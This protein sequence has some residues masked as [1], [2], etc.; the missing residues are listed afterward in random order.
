MR[1]IQ[2]LAIGLLCAGAS[3]VA[4]AADPAAKPVLVDRIAAVV[5]DDVVLYREYQ[6]RVERMKAALGKRK[7]PQK[8]L[9]KTALDDLIND[10][11]IMHVARKLRIRVTRKEIDAAI[12]QVKATNKVNDTQLANALQAQGYSMARYRQELAQQIVR[13]KTINLAVRPRMQI[14]E[15]EL[16]AEY[17][18]LVKRHGKGQVKPFAQLRKQLHERMFQ[19]DLLKYTQMWLGELRSMSYISVR[20]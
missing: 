20:L 8:K 10:K 16:R 15:A 7:V 6:H 12:A 19:R 4:H 2:L 5:N 18:K 14:S 17:N 1:P 3:S 13:M 9:E 11:L